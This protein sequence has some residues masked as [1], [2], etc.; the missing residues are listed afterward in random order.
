MQVAFGERRHA[1][2]T[3]RRVPID[4]RRPASEPLH[5]PGLSTTGRGG[6]AA[7]PPSTESRQPPAWAAMTRRSAFQWQQGAV[8][9]PTP[10]PD[11]YLD[12][13]EM[14]LVICLGCDE[15]S[16]QSGRLLEQR[17]MCLSEMCDEFTLPAHV[18]RS[19]A[20]MPPRH[21]QEG[22]ILCHA[23]RVGCPAPTA[24]ARRSKADG[25]NDGGRM[26]RR[27]PVPAHR[28]A[29]A[30]DEPS[31]AEIVGAC[32]FDTEQSSVKLPS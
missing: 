28:S 22:F 2:K 8:R 15:L 30:A 6:T 20:H 23:R 5:P 32:P 9:G 7:T 4:G 10:G 29:E 27:W 11:P 25:L 24:N 14:A 3:N 31:M 12:L 21:L 13:R 16:Q 1:R 18:P 19:L 17:R 26:D